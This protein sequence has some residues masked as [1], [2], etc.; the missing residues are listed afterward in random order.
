MSNTVQVVCA[1]TGESHD[2]QPEYKPDAD[3]LRAKCPCG[4]C[5]SAEYREP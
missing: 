3:E 4:R 2:V 5:A 1:R